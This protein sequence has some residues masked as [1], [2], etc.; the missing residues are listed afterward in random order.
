MRLGETLSSDTL[1]HFTGKREYLVNIIENGF[2]PRYCTEDLSMFSSDTSSEYQSHDC[3]IPMVCFCDIPLSKV[4]EHISVYKGYGIGC[5]KAWGIERG[6]TPLVYVKTTSETVI[7]IQNAL[8]SIRS[9]SKIDDEDIPK[10]RAVSENLNRLM[11][12]IK[13]YEGRFVHNDQIFENKRFYDEREWRYVPKIEDKPGGELLDLIR[14]ESLYW[15]VKVAKQLLDNEVTGH[16]DPKVFWAHQLLNKTP[17]LLEL[18]DLELIDDLYQKFRQEMNLKIECIPEMALSVDP[19]TIK[20]IIV[21]KEEDVEP[22]AD[23]LN[24]KFRAGYSAT[25]LTRL[26]TRIIT[27]EQIFDDF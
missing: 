6:I 13:P 22:I 4:K 5:T 17:D 21:E 14:K 23:V 25:T 18:S 9:L 3:D 1:F 7:G 11:K 12:F 16:S 15:A 8:N 2:Y 26:L 19:L 24:K 10:V 27:L 20:Y